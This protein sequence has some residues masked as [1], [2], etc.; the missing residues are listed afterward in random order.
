MHIRNIEVEV[1]PNDPYKN[2]V[3]GREKYGKIRNQVIKM[4]DNGFVL[5]LNNEWGTGK[6]TFVKMLNQDLID[7]KFTTIYFLSL[8]HI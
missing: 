3:L 4:H 1:P 8:I 7:D 2:C 5:A 6:T